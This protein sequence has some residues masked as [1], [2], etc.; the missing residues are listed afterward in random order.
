MSNG[1][2]AYLDEFHTG[3]SQPIIEEKAVDQEWL[4]TPIATTLSVKNVS[5]KDTKLT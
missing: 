1:L 5:P 4:K 2:N 3:L